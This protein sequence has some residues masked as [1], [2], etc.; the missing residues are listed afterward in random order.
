MR[1]PTLPRTQTRRVT[2]SITSQVT[3]TASQADVWEALSDLESHTDWMK[4]AVAIR[5][6]TER[7]SGVGTQFECDTRFGALSTTDVITV[8]DWE[9]GRR[10]GVTHSGLVTGT[11]AF[12]VTDDDS[13]RTISWNET[14]SL[15]WQF[16][17][18]IGEIVARPIMAAVWRSNLSRLVRLLEKR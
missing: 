8:D 5:F 14:L 6:L 15:P 9:E 18:R 10:I 12:E 7:H 11:G 4:D 1:A 16:G 2:I 13:V 3:T 17:G